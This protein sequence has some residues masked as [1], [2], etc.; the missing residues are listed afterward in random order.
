[1]CRH[2]AECPQAV[3]GCEMVIN[4]PHVEDVEYSYVGP[5][6]M[7]EVNDGRNES[8]DTGTTLHEC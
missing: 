7:C 4:C 1:M 8:D 5:V 6:P 3:P 2:M